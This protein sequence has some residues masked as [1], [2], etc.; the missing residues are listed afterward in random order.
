MKRVWYFVKCFLMCL[1]KWCSCFLILFCIFSNLVYY[2]S[3][4]LD[5]NQHLIPGRNPTLSY[6]III[7]ICC[8]IQFAVM[9][10]K[11]FAPP[12]LQCWLLCCFLHAAWDL[13]TVALGWHGFW[14]G[15]LCVYQDI[16]CRSTFLNDFVI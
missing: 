4:F 6:C 2:N 15:S 5:R 1:F 3:W 12:T 7:F 10:L 8:W 9:L 11:I 14:Q 16:P 13:T